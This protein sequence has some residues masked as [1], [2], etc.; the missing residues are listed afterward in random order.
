MFNT[1][2]CPTVGGTLVVPLFGRVTENLYLKIIYN[3]YFKCLWFDKCHKYRWFVA[4][5]GDE[6]PH[7]HLLEVDGFNFLL[8]CGWD[9]T[10]DMVFI[11]NLKKVR[12][13][14]LKAEGCCG[15]FASDWDAL[16]TLDQM[17]GS[18]DNGSGSPDLVPYTWLI[19]RRCYKH[20]TRSLHHHQLCFSHVLHFIPARWLAR[21]MLCC[22]PTPTAPIL[23]LCL[24]QWANLASPVPSTPQ[25]QSTRWDR[26]SST[27][28][29]RWKYRPSCAHL[30]MM[31]RIH[32]PP[33]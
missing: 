29:T 32:A 18:Q 10:F 8:D 33:A 11:N 14:M 12:Q 3:E 23:A 19:L 4:G 16:I 28:C 25:C 24:M 30:S 17:W 6:S 27:M 7:C 13:L 21:S 5:G 26:C 1:S 20:K 22:S 31:K 2:I 9:E 15:S